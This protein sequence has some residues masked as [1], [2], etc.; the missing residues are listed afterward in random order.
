VPCFKAVAVSEATDLSLS[1]MAPAGM[2][3]DTLIRHAAPS[4]KQ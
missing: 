3:A 4:G 2:S 1:L